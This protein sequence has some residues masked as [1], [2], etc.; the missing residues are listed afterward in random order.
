MREV[1]AWRFLW[2]LGIWIVLIFFFLLFCIFQNNH[3]KILET[4]SYLRLSSSLPSLEGKT[5]LH[6]TEQQDLQMKIAAKK[7][8]KKEKHSPE[9]QA[10]FADS[11]KDTGKSFP[12]SSFPFSKSTFC[13]EILSPLNLQGILKSEAQSPTE[14]CLFL[15]GASAV[16][17]GGL[18]F[19]KCGHWKGHFPSLLSSQEQEKLGTRKMAD[20]SFA[21]Q[22]AQS[23]FK[24]S[25]HS[26]L[27]LVLSLF[28]AFSQ[29]V[30][31][32]LQF[33][34]IRTGRGCNPKGLGN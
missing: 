9:E 29:K 14:G 20:G 4:N 34:W 11:K 8:R 22:M 30:K 31:C 19:S 21:L 18:F 16:K 13:W 28:T 15:S 10:W 7:K 12:H 32:H 27:S 1:K 33:S 3:S 26:L 17:H 2:V 6:I 5:A 25:S 23:I 24:S